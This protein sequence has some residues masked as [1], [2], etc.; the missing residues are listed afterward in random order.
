M[1]FLDSR[2]VLG[3]WVKA[4]QVAEEVCFL[5]AG[6]QPQAQLGPAGELA[7]LLQ[8]GAGEQQVA[9]GIQL[10]VGHGGAQVC[11]ALVPGLTLQ[12]GNSL[13]L[14]RVGLYSSCAR[15]SKRSERAPWDVSSRR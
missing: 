13:M 7:G 15:P 1:D 6:G 10:S 11:H 2:D 3:G 9:A 14:S 12:R 5:V 8:G 4:L